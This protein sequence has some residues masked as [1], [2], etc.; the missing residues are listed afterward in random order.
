MDTAISYTHRNASGFVSESAIDAGCFSRT[1]V[2]ASDI[3]TA[4]KH[5]ELQW[6]NLGRR[7]DYRRRKRFQRR[8]CSRC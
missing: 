3:N 4:V 2:V 6:L 1:H 5:T 8:S 7:A